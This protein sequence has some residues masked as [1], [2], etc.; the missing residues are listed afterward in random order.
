MSTSYLRRFAFALAMIAA[1]TPLFASAHQPRLVERPSIEVPLPEVSKAYYGTLSGS[2]HIFHITSDKPFVLYANILVPD[3]AYQK[4]D[5]S[6]V[7]VRRGGAS[8]PLALIGGTSGTWTPM[9]EEFGHDNYLQSGEYKAEAPAGEYD[10]WVSSAQND[11]KYVLAVGEIESF[12]PKEIVNALVLVPQLKRDFFSG[13][14][15]SFFLSPFGAGYVIMMFA[16]AVIFGFSYRYMLHKF[17]ARSKVT[18]PR[19]LGKN[20]GKQDRAIR[21]FIGLGLLLLA[22]TTSWSAWL[23]FFAGFCFFEA[24]FSWCGLYAALG[25]TTCPIE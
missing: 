4:T 24:A 5:V 18:T 12:S 13:S 3:I 11:S 1:L 8:L 16:L 9:F 20:I 6:A 23:L 22:I 10:I 21:A 17:A 7:I 2:P 25:R 14:P 15:I 19:V